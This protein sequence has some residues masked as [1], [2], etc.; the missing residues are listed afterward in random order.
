M[1]IT[2]ELSFAPGVED[3][4][5]ALAEE[6]PPTAQWDLAA[7]AGLQ[8]ILA[9]SDK[10]LQTAQRPMASTPLLRPLSAL[11][12]EFL[13]RRPS[14][15]NAA[16]NQFQVP[17]PKRLITFKKIGLGG[18]FP[19]CQPSLNLRAHCTPAGYKP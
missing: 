16:S 8:S 4:Y 15:T 13:P 18:P 7:D 5:K 6:P 19:I 11:E 9:S 1:D 12:S 14:Q 2:R 17:P 10:A 3:A